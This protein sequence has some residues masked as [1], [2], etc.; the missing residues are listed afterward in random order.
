MS[1][2]GCVSSGKIPTVGFLPEDKRDVN[3]KRNQKKLRV[4]KSQVPLKI[5]NLLF[6]ILNEKEN[7]GM[8]EY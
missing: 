5:K 1:T 3:K 7:K 4:L 2:L 6:D 8:L